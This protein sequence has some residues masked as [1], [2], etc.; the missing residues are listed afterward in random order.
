MEWSVWEEK[1]GEITQGPDWLGQG[2]AIFSI[3]GQIVNILGF[4]GHMV[5][6][7][8]TQFCLCSTKATI[9]DT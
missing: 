7:T 4:G 3:Q 5:S 8:T 6:V 1:I 2:L 9:D